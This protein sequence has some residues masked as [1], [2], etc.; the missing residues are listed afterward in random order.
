MAPLLDF[1]IPRITHGDNV[2]LQRPPILE[3]VKEVVFSL[4]P[5]SAP[6]PDGFGAGFYQTCWQ[7]IGDDLIDAVQ[8]F[9][10]GVQQPRGFSS[11]AI[12][13]IPKVQEAAQWKDFRPISLCNVS[14]KVISKLLTNRLRAMLPRSISPWQT[15]FVPRRGITENILLAQELALDLDRRLRHPN[16]MLKLDMKKAYDRKE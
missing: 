8:E 16:L 6:G 5:K 10:Q 11:A 13:L 7:I 4:S 2:K 1:P 9:F 3:E 14:S 15:G 12:V